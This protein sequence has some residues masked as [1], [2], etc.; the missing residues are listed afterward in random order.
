MTL[1]I[2]CIR[3]GSKSEPILIIMIMMNKT[4]PN[5][6]HSAPNQRQHSGPRN[7]ASLAPE[8]GPECCS[9]ALH[10]FCVPTVSSTVSQFRMIG[11]AEREKCVNFLQVIKVLSLPLSLFVGEWVSLH[12][13][14]TKMDLCHGLA[15]T[16]LKSSLTRQSHSR[17]QKARFPPPSGQD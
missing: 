2:V 17:P 14:V 12:R 16:L 7:R 11:A 4:E 15:V 3:S 5:L 6:L 10:R 1:C 9:E 13:T 8:I